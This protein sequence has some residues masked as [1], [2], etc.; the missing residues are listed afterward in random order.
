[1]KT[2]YLLICLFLN[3][4]VV[5]S[6]WTWQNPR[7]QGN[8]LSSICFPGANTG[9]MAGGC[10]TIIKTTDAGPG[11]PDYDIYPNPAGN[12]IT[13]SGK[14]GFPGKTKIAIYTVTG[15][16]VMESIVK[17]LSRI[18]MDVSSLCRGLYLATIQTHER[19]EVK[20]L[21]IQ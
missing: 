7:P 17:S 9:Y 5:S 19:F 15:E 13:I 1:M 3:S 12:K 6:Q 14:R 16:L 10:G 21:I 8:S 18:D 20:K 4:L 11:K 2:I